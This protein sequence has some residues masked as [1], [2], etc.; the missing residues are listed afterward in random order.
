MT[1]MVTMLGI[2]TGLGLPQAYCVDRL[3]EA[4][5]KIDQMSKGGFVWQFRTTSLITPATDLPISLPTDFNPGKTAVLRGA[6]AGTLTNTTI[7]Y[8]PYKDF[9]NQQH[10]ENAASGMFSAWTFYPNTSPPPQYVMRL[11]PVPAFGHGP[12]TLPFGYHALTNTPLVYGSNYFPTPDEFDSL[13]VDLAVAEV[14]DIYRMSGDQQ[15]KAETM[16]AIMEIIDTYRTDR[17]DLAGL[18]DQMAQAQE[19][20]VEKAK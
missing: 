11:A 12:Y 19:K 3:N 8:V 10:F 7:P 2:K 5:R 14:R 6:T 18:T 17:Y 13:I 4:F 1:S 9:V 20:Q 15:K 16:Q